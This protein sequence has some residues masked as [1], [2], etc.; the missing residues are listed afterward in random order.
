MSTIISLTF[1]LLTFRCCQ[2][3]AVGPPSASCGTSLVVSGGV[4]DGGRGRRNV[5]DKKFQRYAKDNRT[6]LNCTQPDTFQGVKYKC[7]CDWV[8]APDP[9]GEIAAFP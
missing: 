4:V 5:Y 9:A 1:D 8:F 3:D 6:T 7:V 2:Y